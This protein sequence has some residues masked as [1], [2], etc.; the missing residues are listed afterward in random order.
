M[1]SFIRGRALEWSATALLA[2]LI[3]F[4]ILGPS[5]VGLADNGDFPKILGPEGIWPSAGSEQ[6]RYRYFNPEY[7]VR[8]D[9]FYDVH[10]YSLERVFVRLAKF[11]ALIVLPPGT[12]DLRILGVLHGV[13]LIAAGWLF[14]RATRGSPGWVRTGVATLVIF[15]LSDIQYVQFLN[16]AYMDASAVVFCLLTLAVAANALRES[17]PVWPLAFALSSGLFLISKL[18]HAVCALALVL[19]CAAMM[20]RKSAPVRSRYLWLVPVAAILLA[21][22]YIARKTPADFRADSVFGV[23]FGKLAPRDSQA[24]SYFGF[25]PDDAKYTG[26][27]NAFVDGSP[28]KDPAYR[29]YLLDRVPARKLAAY[30]LSHPAIVW[31]IV[32]TDL[33]AFG[34]DPSVRRLGKLRRL[35]NPQERAQPAA[36]GWWSKWKAALLRAA[37]LVPL[38]LIGAVLLINAVL[39]RSTWTAPLLVL[40]SLMA[41]LSLFVATLGDSSETE[42]HLILYHVATDFIVTLLIVSGIFVWRNEERLRT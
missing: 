2:L 31:D 39:V 12:F 42:R 36:F 32:R 22:N 14:F 10:I 4:Q 23:V 20:L 25:W 8:D 21:F 38:I 3:G 15:I 29:G 6:D 19:F 17:H 40:G 35:D 9:R 7:V 1:D 18:Q 16:T 5:P 37:P 33:A 34:W 41:L 28:M 13:V 24:L 11:V 30:Y 26:L 27:R